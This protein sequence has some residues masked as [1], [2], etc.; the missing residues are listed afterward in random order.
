M[1]R[2]I[3]RHDLLTRI[4]QAF[5]MSSIVCLL[6]PRQCGK[7]TLARSL[8]SES[9]KTRDDPGYFDLERPRDLEAL[10][11]PDLALS[12]L[13]GLIVIDEIQRKPDLFPYLR[14]LHDEQFDQKFL[15]LGSA[16]KDLIQQSS[17]SLAGR[18]VYI[19][20]TP[21]SLDEA[22]EWQDLWVKGGFPKSY[23]LANPSSLIWRENYMRT[24]IEQDLG[25]LGF[26]FQGDV[27]RK[28][29]F[30]L[31]HY[32]GNILNASE[33]ANAMGVSQPTITR[34]LSYLGGG[35]MIRSLK[36]WFENLKKRQVKSPKIYYR[37]SGLLHYSLGIKSYSDILTHPKAGAS[38]EG[39]AMEEVIKYYQVDDC[40]FWASHNN[41]EL[42]LLLIKDGKRLGFEFKLS[43]APKITPSM[44]IAMEDLKL[45][46]LKII[47]PGNRSY[48][49]G[50]GMSVESIE[51]FY[52]KDSTTVCGERDRLDL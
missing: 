27:L 10:Q 21:F 2:H 40:Y 47:Y 19:E 16:T 18:I 1:L 52:K 41:A 31:A 30:M 45:D 13:K 50:K 7:T 26:N 28:L 6:G 3:P 4:R 8:W 12:N 25:N 35:F 15:I 17:E 11:T 39:F 22:Q 44:R 43:D 46:S 33:L 32:H 20:V 37:D 51:M 42:D 5:T 9:D 14:Y 34:Y 29:W 23:L 36:P 38:W 24:Y 49:L 48:M